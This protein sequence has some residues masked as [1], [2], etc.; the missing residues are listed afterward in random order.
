M[1]NMDT[2]TET[3]E[4]TT[5]T[6]VA[7][8]AAAAAAEQVRPSWMWKKGKKL[9]RAAQFLDG[10]AVHWYSGDEFSHLD[11]AYISMADGK[12]NHQRR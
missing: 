3:E 7:T 8:A 1:E 4:T 6:T 10:L 5:T 11:E 12:K 2:D 9:S